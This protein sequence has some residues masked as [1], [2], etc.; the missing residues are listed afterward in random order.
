[1]RLT[2]PQLEISRNEG[3]SKGKDIFDRKQ[4]G[5][6]LANLFVTIVICLKPLKKIK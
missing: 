2:V 1:M 5:E 4:F 3:F 6:R